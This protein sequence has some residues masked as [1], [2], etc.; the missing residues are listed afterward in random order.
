MANSAAIAASG[1]HAAR[2]RAQMLGETLSITREF[3]GEF[4]AHAN[5][6]GHFGP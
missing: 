1:A 2:L 4:A 5:R 6:D 3:S